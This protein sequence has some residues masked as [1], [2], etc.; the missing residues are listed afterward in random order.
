MINESSPLK[1]VSKAVQVVIFAEDILIWL[2]AQDAANQQLRMAIRKLTA[3]DS[4]V[5]LTPRSIVLP[6][7]VDKIT[8]VPRTGD[9]G[10]FELSNDESN[11]EHKALLE[12][13]NEHAGGAMVS[14][15]QYYWIMNDG[16]SI[17]RKPANQVKRKS[18]S[19]SQ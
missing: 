12:F 5:R 19:D 2:D 10:P 17:G 4:D 11:P 8:W 13:L 3:Q 16:K 6:F 18:S 9:K 1:S 7:H 14:E 15:G